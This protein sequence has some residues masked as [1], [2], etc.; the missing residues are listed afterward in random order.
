[1]SHVFISY[2]RED[3]P[4]ARALRDLLG[5]RLHC[6]VFWDQDLQCGGL[7]NDALDDALAR[8]ACVVVIWS[9]HSIGS[10][11][12]QQEAA[13]GRVFDKL[14]PVTIDDSEIPSAFAHVQTASLAGLASGS[15]TRQ[16]PKSCV[17]SMRS[18]HTSTS[19]RCPVASLR[20]RP[21]REWP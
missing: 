17:F 13:V 18:P 20:W 4:S 16:T 1:M 5:N 19:R 6:K 8:A 3:L 15:L 21:T 10:S 11:W 14:V 12:V 2:K 9:E 7:W